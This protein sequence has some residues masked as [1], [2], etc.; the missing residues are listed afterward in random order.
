VFCE[1]LDE[2][3]WI[4]SP[5]D[6]NYFPMFSTQQRAAYQAVLSASA[7]LAEDGVFPRLLHDPI[8]KLGQL[9]SAAAA[10]WPKPPLILYELSLAISKDVIGSAFHSVALVERLDGTP[11]S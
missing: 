5:A 7:Q 4:V 8:G 9:E 6:S 11:V 3:A 10:C 2:E 1:T